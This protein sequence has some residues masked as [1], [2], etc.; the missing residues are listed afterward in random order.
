[1]A[2][3]AFAVFLISQIYLGLDW[4]AERLGLARDRGLPVH[5]SSVWRLGDPPAHAPIPT[6][7]RRR[8]R[9]AGLAIGAGALGVLSLA[10]FAP[11]TS[12]PAAFLQI[13]TSHGVATVTDLVHHLR[14]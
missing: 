7:S 8:V 13:C 9:R 4:L 12:E 2:C 3:C 14:P 6:P 5:A 10:A 11:R 1:M